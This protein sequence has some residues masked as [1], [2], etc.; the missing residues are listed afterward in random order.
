MTTV[1]TDDEVLVCAVPLAAPCGVDAD[2][3]PMSEDGR[4]YAELAREVEAVN[5]R[6][7]RIEQIKRSRSSTATSPSRT[8]S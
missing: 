7:A 6:L 2:P 4:V 3:A 5:E 8:V 1:G